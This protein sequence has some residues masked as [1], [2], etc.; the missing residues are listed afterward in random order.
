M[1]LAEL[2]DD[3]Y[4][5]FL[6]RVAE[7]VVDNMDYKTMDAILCDNL[8]QEYETY[9]KED[10]EIELCEWFEE[11]EFNSIMKKVTIDTCEDLNTRLGARTL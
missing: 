7:T 9:N 4:K 10:F 11:D 3:Q 2:T 6:L 8:I 5:E 1:K